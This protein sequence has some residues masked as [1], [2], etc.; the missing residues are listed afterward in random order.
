TEAPTETTAPPAATTKAP[1]DGGTCLG[2][3]LLVGM[4]AAGAA[5]VYRRRN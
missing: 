3:I 2:T 4:L 1:E 5:L